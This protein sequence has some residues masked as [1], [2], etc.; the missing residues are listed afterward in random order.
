M[1]TSNKTHIKSQKS[2]KERESCGKVGTLL[3]FFCITVRAW[4]KTF[5]REVNKLCWWGLARHIPKSYDGCEIASAGKLLALGWPS[6]QTKVSKK[7][8]K[9]NVYYY[10]CYFNSNTAP[11]SVCTENGTGCSM[12]AGA[13]WRWEALSEVRHTVFVPGLSATMTHIPMTLPAWG[14]GPSRSWPLPLPMSTVWVHWASHALD[15]SMAMQITLLSQQ[16]NQGVVFFFCDNDLWTSLF[17]QAMVLI[18]C[19][20]STRIKSIFTYA[21]LTN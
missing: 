8:K 15:S 6:H 4:L 17:F 16:S 9:A 11:S 18:N 2:K 13:I 10:H 19:F 1:V 7:E 20:W 5:P 14:H 12:P 3:S 21:I